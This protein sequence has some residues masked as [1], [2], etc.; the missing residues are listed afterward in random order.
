MF[1]RRD[2]DRTSAANPRHVCDSEVQASSEEVPGPEAFRHASATCR[3]TSATTA[4]SRKYSARG[5][6]DLQLT[7][8]R[9]HRRN[10]KGHPRHPFQLAGSR[11]Y[12]PLDRVVFEVRSRPRGNGQ[13]ESWR[14]NA[15][16]D[17]TRCTF[18]DCEESHH[19][20]TYPRSLFVE[21]VGPELSTVDQTLTPCKR[22]FGRC[23]PSGSEV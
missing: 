15:P 8:R 2:P 22:K 3:K 14:T 7:S 21:R 10:P 11:T 5:R 13:V 9:I 12:R 20:V 4:R 23:R 16:L 1:T 18:G 19:V 17:R 6:R